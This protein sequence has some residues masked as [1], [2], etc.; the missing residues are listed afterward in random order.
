[1]L[2][3]KNRRGVDNIASGKF[4]LGGSSSA[5]AGP[6]GRTAMAMTDGEFKAEIYSYARS[7]GLFIGVAIDGGAITIDRDG[8][9]QWYGSD[10]NGASSRI[11]SDTSLATPEAAKPLLAT[12][13]A[14]APS[15]T[16]RSDSAATPAAPPAAGPPAIRQLA[17]RP[18][19]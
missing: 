17:A 6:V 7:R 3:F 18:I 13:T 4:T 19:R 2:V 1:M 16:W 9:A 10:E 8:N 5:S 14:M 11:F 12:L 15:L